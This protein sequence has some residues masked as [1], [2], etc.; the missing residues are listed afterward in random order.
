M[1]SL[2]VAYTHC[3]RSLLPL[4]Q[5]LGMRRSVIHGA[6]ENIDKALPDPRLARFLKPALGTVPVATKLPFLEMVTQA[7]T[8]GWGRTSLEL[9]Q[10]ALRNRTKTAF[11]QHHPQRRV[12]G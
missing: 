10:S 5:F 2:L 3:R 6:A 12:I 7:E 4:P 8:Y 9:R 11:M 1:I